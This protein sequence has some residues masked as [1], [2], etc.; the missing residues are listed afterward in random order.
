M[1]LPTSLR[2]TV[3]VSIVTRNV[4]WCCFEFMILM[5]TRLYFE[6]YIMSH[7][8]RFCT[9]F[10]HSQVNTLLFRLNSD[11]TPI[12]EG[13]ALLRETYFQPHRVEREGGLDPLLRGQVYFPAQ[14]V[15][16]HMVDEM[17]NMLF[18]TF[19]HPN[20]KST[21]L[22]LASINIQRGRDHGIPDFNTVRK[23][24]GLK[25]MWLCPSVA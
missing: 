23:S 13:H 20:G 14:E 22:D 19:P 16:T 25:G 8:N 7:C 3:V 9:R 21:G 24:L 10:G 1:L 18:T 17:R 6:K 15:D 5:G 11:K 4:R 12:K 2:A